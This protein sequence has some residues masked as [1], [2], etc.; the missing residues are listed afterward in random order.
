MYLSV[1]SLKVL[2]NSLVLGEKIR[3]G[4]IQIEA[5]T[6]YRKTTEILQSS[7]VYRISGIYCQKWNIIF[8]N[9]FSLVY[10]HLKIRIMFSLPWI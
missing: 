5:Y 4:F 9:R 6:L 8:M 7:P 2:P 3:Y 1:E 10:N